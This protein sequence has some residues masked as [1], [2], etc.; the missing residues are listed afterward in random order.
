M[1]QTKKYL[2]HHSV[3][4]LEGP[5]VS[6]ESHEMETEGFCESFWFP[7]MGLSPFQLP[8]LLPVLNTDVTPGDAAAILQQISNKH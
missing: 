3:V 6:G 8:L 7:N 2:L 4:Q 1:C 5:Y